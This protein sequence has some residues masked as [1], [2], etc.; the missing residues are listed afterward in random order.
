MNRR[1]DN[2]TA[3]KVTLALRIRAEFGIDAAVRYATDNHLP[4]KLA[5]DVFAR[6]SDEVRADVPWVDVTCGRRRADR[7][8]T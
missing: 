6:R 2:I 3:E 4:E 5:V 7:R 1:T 8:N